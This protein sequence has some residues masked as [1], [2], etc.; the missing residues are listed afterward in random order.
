MFLNLFLQLRLPGA[1]F[2]NSWGLM[3]NFFFVSCHFISSI[4]YCES[5]LKAALM[6]CN[7]VLN[8][9]SFTVQL[10]IILWS[11]RT[12]LRLWAAQT[13]FQVQIPHL[14]PDEQPVCV[15]GSAEVA[16]SAQVVPGLGPRLQPYYKVL[17]F[18]MPL[19]HYP[20]PRSDGV[21]YWKSCIWSGADEDAWKITFCK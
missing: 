21:K 12:S 4:K 19:E 13:L 14:D 5:K 17:D 10:N 15:G 18:C 6:S 16:G 11:W 2:N 3:F 20:L 8:V 7:F 1:L 9:L